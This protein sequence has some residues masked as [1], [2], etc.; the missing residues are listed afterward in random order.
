MRSL[1]FQ[2]W[3][4]KYWKNAMYINFPVV[5]FEFAIIFYKNSFFTFFEKETLPTY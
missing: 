2:V 4:P 1:N 3:Q 5:K